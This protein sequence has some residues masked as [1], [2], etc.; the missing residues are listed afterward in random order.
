MEN[1]LYS[2]IVLNEEAS[3]DSTDNTTTK[4]KKKSSTKKTPSE[5]TLNEE[6]KETASKN[7]GKRGKRK[8]ISEEIEKPEKKTKKSTKNEIAA[9]TADKESKEKKNKKT[10]KTNL[11][12]IA[13]D[14]ELRVIPLGGME[15][16]GKNMT[17]FECEGDA[18][19]LDCGMSFPDDDLPGVDAVIPDFTYVGEIRDSIRGLV[20]THGHEDHIGGIVYLLKQFPGIPIY[21]T[22]LTMGL[23]KY[24]LE[25][26]R[27]ESVSELHVVHAGDTIG[28]GCFDVEFI[29]MN[30]SIPDACALAINSPAG[31][32]IHTGDFKIDYTPV[33][34]ETADLARLGEY[35]RKGV[36]ALMCDSTNAEN[37][38]TSTTEAKVGASFEALFSRAEGKRVIIATFSSNIYRIQ[39]IID[40][41]ENHGRKIAL[42]GRS[43]INYVSIAQELGYLRY[44][45]DTI[46]DVN[47]I[48][49]YR[50]ED[51]VIIT[52]GSQGEPFSALTRMA[53]GD[54]K[55]I[56]I[57][58]NDCIIIS[59]KP[60]PGNEKS[61]TKVINALL[62]MGSDVIYESMYEIHASGHA[63]RDEIRLVLT[64]TQPAY[65]MPVHG[66]VKHLIKNA[67]IAKIKG[68]PDDR[69]IL[70]KI[71]DVISF[72]HGKVRR[73]EPVT[74]GRVLVD[75]YGVGDVGA[76]V[77]RDRQHLASDGLMVV[78]CSIDM[79][80]GYLIGGPDI[81]SRGFVYVKESE[82]LIEE[83]RE[84]AIKV[85]GEFEGKRNRSRTDISAELRDQLGVLLYR[86]TKRNP[87]ILPVIMEI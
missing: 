78:V 40:F 2:E 7:D 36:L 71:G 54:H 56:K 63:C 75:G 28:L 20:L 19:I 33:F 39:Q 87:M 57:T 85:V 43:M 34:G 38:G 14:A 32:I 31:T 49:R 67:D 79:M 15:E 25:E 22:P 10:K 13:S 44:K 9:E 72:S 82:E 53:S 4:K 1:K 77:L 41:A 60:I 62:S 30:H 8:S 48:G 65:F 42:S 51:L 64:L 58:P 16:I 17:V 52:T 55:Q 59:S 12:K 11:G 66:E 37:L 46:I 47:A 26:N 21:G 81:V 74:A 76:V 45:P 80:T 86:K 18:F 73:E 83:V 27:L 6:K 35:G 68:M 3:Q 61:V 23:V 70:A 5:T 50:D 69:I 84:L 29:H 24:K